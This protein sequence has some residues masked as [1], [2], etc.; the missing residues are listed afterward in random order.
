MKRTLTMVAVAMGILTAA[1]AFAAR[2]DERQAN[3]EARI[4]EGVQSGEL[5]RREAA[6]LE[7]KHHRLQHEIR[8]DRRDDGRLTRGEKRRLER[9][10]NRLSRQIGREKH[11]AQERR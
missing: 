6:R 11:D 4:R 1:P 3:Q 10:Q 9:Q 8:R 5:T 2:A 7:R